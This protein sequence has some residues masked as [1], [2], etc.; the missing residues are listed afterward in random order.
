M[1][2]ESKL[3]NIIEELVAKVSK[4]FQATKYL[5]LFNQYEEL[6]Q[7]DEANPSV[8]GQLRKNI[9][10]PLVINNLKFITNNKEQYDINLSANEFCVNIKYFDKVTIEKMQRKKFNLLLNEELN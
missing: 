1:N 7:E 6:V 4:M 8:E 3:Y 5:K 2:L 9:I 10:E